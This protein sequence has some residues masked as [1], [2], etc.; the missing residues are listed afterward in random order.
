MDIVVVS[1]NDRLSQQARHANR[2]ETAWIYIYKDMYNACDSSPSCL[3]EDCDSHIAVEKLMDIENV[4]RCSNAATKLEER[5]TE[6]QRV[7]TAAQDGKPDRASKSQPHGLRF[8]AIMAA[9]LSS[10][11]LSSLVSTKSRQSVNHSLT[12]MQ[13]ENIIGTATSQI[14]NT[15]HS[16]HDVGW[17]GSA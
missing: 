4:P 17:Y 2:Q 5:G 6:T 15:F 1:L 3:V 7:S 9:A 12:S 13:D 14:T 16:L 11:F 10:V 8:A